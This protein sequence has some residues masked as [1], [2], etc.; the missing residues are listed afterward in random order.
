[1]AMRNPRSKER[2]DGASRAD[3]LPLR[4][5]AEY[6]SWLP[7]FRAVAECGGVV[8]AGRALRTSPSAL[9][10][11]VRL[12]EG[13]VGEPLFSRSGRALVLTRAGEDLLGAARL[14]MRTIH[15]AA[16]PAREPTGP[17][18]IG[19]TSRLGTVRLLPALRALR[20]RSPGITPTVSSVGHADVGPMLLAGRLDLA[21]TLAR[22]DQTELACDELAPAA[23][24]VFCGRGH[25][26]FGKPKARPQEI[27]RHAFAAPAGS[28]GERE[29]D[30]WPEHLDRRV[31]VRSS[32]IEPGVDACLHGELLAVLPRE[33]VEA[34]GLAP[35][36]REL[37]SIEIPAA[38]V[39]AVRRRAAAG[40][41]WPADLV[42]ALLRPSARSAARATSARAV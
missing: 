30:G 18:A 28:P 27:L 37:P 25:P 13:A 3:L 8:Q 36:L 40:R 34:L 22:I 41:V 15:D 31:A 33:V 35:R 24:G 4:Q 12:L 38:R 10:R 20:R 21:I 14:A 16:T 17:V 1:M 9:S 6:W 23:S 39:F 11:A 2:R 5:V 42:A 32:V 7:S 26:L 19:T 29:P